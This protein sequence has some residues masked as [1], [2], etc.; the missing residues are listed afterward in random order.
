MKH[1]YIYTLLFITCFVLV[2]EFSFA[3]GCDYGGGSIAN[4]LE[5]C[6]SG[7]DLVNPGDA[8]IES[9]VK[10]KLLDWTNAIWWLL[11]LLAVGAI[12]YGAFIMTVSGWDDERIKKGKDIVKWSLVWFF[13]LI[14]AGSLLRLVTEVI[15]SV[16]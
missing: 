7:T 9:G 12:V 6:L 16:A 11:G 13:A 5:G 8:L 14:S 2:P 4:E 10:Q 3:A 1:T 15:F